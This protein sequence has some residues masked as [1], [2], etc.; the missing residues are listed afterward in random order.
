MP[1]IAAESSPIRLSWNEKNRQI[2]IAPKDNDLYVQT[3]QEV[4]SALRAEGADARGKTQLQFEALLNRLGEWNRAHGD[5]LTG[6]YLTLRDTNLLFLVVMK[7][8]SHDPQ[9]EDDLTELDLSIAR[10]DAFDL[11]SVSVLAI[12]HSDEDCIKSFIN[13]NLCYTYKGPY[14]K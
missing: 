1:R 6:V 8:K 5:K 11:L 10:D 12:P 4:I 13:E 3:V 2:V 14:A 9:L 7:G